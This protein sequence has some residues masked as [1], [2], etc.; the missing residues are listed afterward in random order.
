MF[1]GCA[2]KQRASDFVQNEK[3]SARNG[4]DH[5]LRAEKLDL[6]SILFLENDQGRRERGSRSKITGP[7]FSTKTWEGVNQS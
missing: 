3:N 7:Y 4:Q 6:R 5:T 1:S 2:S